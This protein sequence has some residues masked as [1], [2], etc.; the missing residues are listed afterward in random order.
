VDAVARGEASTAPARAGVVLV[1]LILVAAVANLNLSVANVALPSIGEA[2]DS[3]QVM[4]NLIAVGYSLGL[5]A[6][7][8]YL[9]ALARARA[10]VWS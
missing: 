6:S 9:G 5:A 8:L 10:G 3:G 7:V 2:F 1:T 4:L